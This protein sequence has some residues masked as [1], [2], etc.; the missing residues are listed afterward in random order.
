LGHYGFVPDIFIEF[1]AMPVLVTDQIIALIASLAPEQVTRL[2]TEERQ[3]FA[4]WCRRAAELAE[5]P[6]NAQHRAPTQR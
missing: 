1:L 4:E 6:P 5:P 2:P 3:R